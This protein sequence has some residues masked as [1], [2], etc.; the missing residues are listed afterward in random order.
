MPQ[1]LDALA[2]DRGA[3]N[4]AGSLQL[5]RAWMRLL[6]RAWVWLGMRLR[7]GRLSR[8]VAWWR[9]QMNRRRHMDRRWQVDRRR[10]VAG[11]AR[12]ESQESEGNEQHPHGVDRV[13]L[14][15]GVDKANGLKTQWW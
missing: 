6:A 13:L 3:A 15:S 8:V 10:Q 7:P 12:S 11:G 4:A 14:R 2:Q 9:R 1:E 5:A